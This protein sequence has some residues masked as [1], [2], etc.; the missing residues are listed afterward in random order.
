MRVAMPVPCQ[1]EL[2]GAPTPGLRD[3]VSLQLS[4]QPAQEPGV[5]EHRGG[6]PSPA[7][8]PEA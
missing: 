5:A 3:L 6:P 8:A 7:E 1:L 2:L 4:G